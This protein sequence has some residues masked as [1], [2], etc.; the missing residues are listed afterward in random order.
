MNVE[1]NLENADVN[2][3]GKVTSTD[4]TILKRYLTKIIKELPI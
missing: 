4:V 1:I 2:T 3:D